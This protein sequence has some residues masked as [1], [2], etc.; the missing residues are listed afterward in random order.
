MN[1]FKPE[2]TSLESDDIR[3][4][5]ENRI[6]RPGQINGSDKRLFLPVWGK[7]CRLI[8]GF[9]SN[10]ISKVNAGPAFDADQWE[11]ICTTLDALLAT[12]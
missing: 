2:W 6:G 4:L 12:R 3:T 11:K 5:I 1:L 9:S 8:L 10:Q 7:Q